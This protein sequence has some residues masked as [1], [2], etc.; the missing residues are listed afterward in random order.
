MRRLMGTLYEDR[1]IFISRSILLRI[2]N[3]SYKSCGEIQN[4]HLFSLN[5]AP[6]FGFRKTATAVIKPDGW[7]DG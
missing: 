2:R 6:A 5:F 1:R 7:M 4:T 3:V